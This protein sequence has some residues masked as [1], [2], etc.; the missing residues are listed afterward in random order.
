[1]EKN[2]ERSAKVFDHKQAI[3]D[4]LVYPTDW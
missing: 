1:M 2:W 4:G 3:S